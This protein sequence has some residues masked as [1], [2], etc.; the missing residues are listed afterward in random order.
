MHE[1]HNINND[2]NPLSYHII[3]IQIKKVRL[4]QT[5]EKEQDLDWS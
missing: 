4:V 1:V 5:K 3:C 2:V